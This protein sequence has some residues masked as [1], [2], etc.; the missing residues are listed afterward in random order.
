ME[1]EGRKRWIPGLMMRAEMTSV[2]VMQRARKKTRTKVR[3]HVR[4]DFFQSSHSKSRY[5]GVHHQRL[6]TAHMI[7]SP[8]GQGVLNNLNKMKSRLIRVST[9]VRR[10]NS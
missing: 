10:P 6:E 9:M 2:P 5:K 3:S 1:W 4:S 7:W 8:P